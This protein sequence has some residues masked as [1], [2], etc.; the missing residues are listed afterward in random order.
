[1]QHIREEGRQ[2]VGGLLVELT[3]QAEPETR[4]QNGNL[5]AGGTDVTPL[6]LDLPPL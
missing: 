1:M 2:G 4:L 6:C 5:H 3:L